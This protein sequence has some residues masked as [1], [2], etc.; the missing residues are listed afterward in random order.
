M[1]R[2]NR[3]GTVRRVTVKSRS[4]QFRDMTDPTEAIS[5]LV[6]VEFVVMSSIVLL[7]VPLDVAA[8]LVPLLSVFLVALHLFRS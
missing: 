7:L 6:V 1:V 8:P 4:E 2:A 3:I 5:L